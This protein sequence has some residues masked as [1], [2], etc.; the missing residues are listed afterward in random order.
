MSFGG[1][2]G[3]G[4][5]GGERNGGDSTVMKVDSAS[6]GRIIGKGGSKIRQLEQDSQARIKISREEDDYGKKE[7][8]IS[9]TPDE[10]AV[11]K[12]MIEEC[13]SQGNDYS[14]G[15]GR[16]GGGFG[17]RDRGGGYDRR[18]RDDGGRSWGRRDD[19]DG[20]YRDNYRGDRDRGGFGGRGGGAAG[21]DQETIFVE[22]TEVGRIIGRGGT[23]IREMEQDSGCRIKVSRDPDGY[24]RSS[25]ELSGS[26]SQISK[27]KDLIQ[28]CGVDI[29]G[30]NARGW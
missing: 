17:G 29:V 8:E 24:G 23:R 4:G 28:D 1:N 20:G 9:G 16:R 21:G 25:V 19:R 18:D 3:R 13:L 11:A 12:E 5:G 26:K 22:S 30:D 10:I 7:V 2:Y 15:G 27:A 6:V 14:G